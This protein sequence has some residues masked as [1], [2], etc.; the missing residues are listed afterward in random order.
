MCSLYILSSDVY[1]V[2]SKPLKYHDLLHLHKLCEDSFYIC[3][4]G[5]Y[6]LS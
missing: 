4:I 2:L 3:C 6:T 5:G 1:N